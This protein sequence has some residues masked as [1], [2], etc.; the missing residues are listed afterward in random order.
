MAQPIT[1]P[2]LGF[3]TQQGK[4][5][6]WL[7]Q[8]GDSVQ[9][10]EPVAEVEADKVTMEIVATMGG[11]LLQQLATVGQAVSTGETIGLVGTSEEA[12]V[13][14]TP[15]TPAPPYPAPISS[16]TPP[17]EPVPAFGNDVGN[18]EEPLPNVRISPVARRLALENGLALEELQGSGPGGFILKADV[19]ARLMQPLTQPVIRRLPPLRPVGTAP[20]PPVPVTAA[21]EKTSE[22]APTVETTGVAPSS[23]R[24]AIAQR[25]TQSKTSVPHFYITKAIF[26]DAALALRAQI[27]AALPDE[28]K[29]TVND[30]VVKA[31]ALVLREFPQLNA[32]FVGEQIVQHPDINIGMAVAVDGGLLT[33]VQRHCDKATISTIAAE[34]KQR[35]ARA[36]AGKVKPDDISGATFTI[37]NLGAYDVEHF[38]PI[39]NPPEGA[40][41]GVA[42]AK[43]TPVVENGQVVVRTQMLV[44]LAADHRLTDGVEAAQFLQR[45]KE[46]LENPLLVV[47]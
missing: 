13:P 21:V 8:V 31:V 29:V 46:K 28:Q 35:F 34:N 14:T 10:G 44:T 19:Q 27:N 42:T 16:P 1:I 39:I 7:K 38:A 32:S 26:M 12:N 4:L 9:P 15:S 41:L 6:H 30:L 23:L 5:A 43:P 11:V 20:T 40:I 25:M 36:R 33:V 45:L 3:D 22:P 17:P 24:R 2:E 47:I 18:G 37:S